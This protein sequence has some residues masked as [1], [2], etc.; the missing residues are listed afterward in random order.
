MPYNIETLLKGCPLYDDNVNGEIF[1]A[2]Q[3][4]IFKSN[5]FE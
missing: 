3:N 5:R 4:F 2:V 1:L